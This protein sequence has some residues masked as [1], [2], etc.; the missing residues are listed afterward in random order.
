[1]HR[2]IWLLTTLLCF[3]VQAAPTHRESV[4]WVFPNGSV[5]APSISLGDTTTGFYRSSANQLA[6]TISGSRR[7]NWHYSSGSVLTFHPDANE[8]YYLNSGNATGLASVSGDTTSS[9]GRNM[10][11]Y[12]ASHATLPNYFSLRRG[13][14]GDLEINTI[15]AVS[16]T[17][18]A[19]NGIAVR[20]GR[21]SLTGTTQ[22]VFEANN[23]AG[24]V[25]SGASSN[26]FVF[27]SNSNIPAI[28]GGTVS[29]LAHFQHSQAANNAA[30]TITREVSFS[31]S[32][33]KASGG[34]TSNY[35]AFADNFA[36]TGDY[37]LNIS[38]TN[39]NRLG[40]ALN[41]IGNLRIGSSGSAPTDTL[42]NLVTSANV[43]G[44]SQTV[45]SSGLAGDSTATTQLIGYNSGI[46]T[47]NSAFTMAR[48]LH[49]NF[50]NTAKGAASTIT[51]VV[52]YMGTESTQGTNNAF[53]ADN[54]SFTGNW[55]LNFSS[56]NASRFS[57]PLELFNQQELRLY[58]GTSGAEYVLV[59]APSSVT[60]NRTIVL[61]G[62]APSAGQ[63]VTT[64][65]SGNWTYTTGTNA[66][67]AVASKTGAYTIASGDD[68][69]LA[70]A[71]GGAFT[72]TL[73]ASA[74]NTG[75]IFR[76]KNTGA[77][78]VVTIDGNAAETLDGSTTL[79]LHAQNEEAEI[80]MDGTN[81]RLLGYG[82]VSGRYTPTLTSVTNVGASTSN[83]IH[84]V[85]IKNT[86]MV[87]GK[88]A[89]DPT[90][91]AVNTELGI[92]LPIASNLAAAT[93]CLGT[94]TNTGDSTR[95]LVSGDT[96]NDRAQMG[97]I[98]ASGGNEDVYFSFSYEIK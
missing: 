90:S 74:S 41:V 70:D 25:G 53:M 12:G 49:F 64:D 23:S 69:I 66:A 63:Y 35:A 77:T 6:A 37:G 43:T 40:G 85:K 97:M 29:N 71:S 83:S 16:F 98:P 32:G 27:R 14:T 81:V 68:V 15:G 36:F 7:F 88:V 95:C 44:A 39:L 94:C 4:P 26:I 78:G 57:G 76:I 5:S 45:I 11:L 38:S 3:A 86:V 75:K 96:T 56:T 34:T 19:A 2:F 73:P 87:F 48:L 50:N 18:T 80:L 58:E 22:T 47:A 13:T 9:S 21:T 62:I 17:G 24:I 1:M 8:G 79:P 54:L 93:D 55:L 42:V 91:A 46:T 72:L 89:I 59:K 51:R 30:N 84:Y 28:S 61:P 52:G 92:S 10:Q 20:A 82:P 67:L 65:G 60:A 33:G 31:A